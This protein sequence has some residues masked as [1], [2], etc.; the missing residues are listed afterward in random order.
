VVKALGKQFADKGDTRKA[1]KLLEKNLKN[2][3]D[4]YMSRAN[5]QED[6]AM[7]TKKPLGGNSCASCA[8]DILDI[9]GK[10]VDF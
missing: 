1:L 8:K 4:L 9:Y 5:D 2:L 7:F 10:R 6:E 3:Y